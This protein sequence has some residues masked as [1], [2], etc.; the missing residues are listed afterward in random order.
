VARF[1]HTAD[2]HL[3][4]I[5]HG[6]H[7]TDDQAHA[8]DQ[9]ITLLGDLQPD[10]VVLAGDVFDR[11]VPPA[12]AVRLFADTARRIVVD[13]GLPFIVIAGNHDDPVRL[14]AHDA[15]LREQGLH[16]VGPCVDPPPHVDVGDTRFHA[17]PFADVPVMRQVCG[18][19]AI[20]DH[21]EAIGRLLD[22]CD[23]DPTRANVAIAHTVVAGAE[24]CDSERDL[25][26]GG[27][28]SV[29]TDRFDRF[30]Y[31]AL[32]HLH[33]PQA[34]GH[35]RLR[36]SG[37]LLKY[38]ISEAG[39]RKGV[40]LVDVAP[41]RPASYQHLPIRPRRDVRVIRTTPEA[42]PTLPTTDDYV[43][44]ELVTEAS[45]LDPM[46]AARRSC[47]NAISLEIV[48]PDRPDPDPA[49]TPDAAD[50]RDLD[51]ATLFARFA[52]HA[53]D[54]VLSDEQQAEFAEV[55]RAVRL[56]IRGEA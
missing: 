5:L 21:A 47:N 13:L 33:R 55:A 4:R 25:H 14:A 24:A 37:S 10:A 29:P 53:D 54:A 41:G 32:G 56:E 48:R 15:L 23:H 2:W 30:D 6:V 49:A 26:I 28:G 3:G 11:A 8:L 52:R 18:D 36:Y 51:D 50:H 27:S 42:L 16:I 31:V 1:L 20:T 17:I 7:L 46:T 40:G 12:E 34:C 39:H 43:H 45:P 9:V 22:S 44:V 19:E 35:D 38:S